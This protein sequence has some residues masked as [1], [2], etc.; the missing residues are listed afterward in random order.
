M[1]PLLSRLFPIAICLLLAL[2]TGCTSP[3]PAAPQATP[4]PDLPG[5]KLA[6]HDEFD[7][8]TG[9]A[10]DAA[11][12][13]YDTGG[14]G[15]GNG[16]LEYYTRETTNAAMDGK[17]AL[18]IQALKLSQ[19]GAGGLK[20]WYGPCQYTSA[21]LLTR[22]KYEFTYGRAEARLKIPAGQGLWPGFW[23]LGS[24]IGTTPWPACGEID[25]LENIGREPS[26]AHGTVHG[27]GYSG[28]GG[29]GGPFTLSSGKLADDFHVYAVE[30]EPKEIRWYLDGKQ[31]FS[32][33]PEK[34]N[35]KWVFDHPFFLILNVAVGGQWPGAPDDA[36]TVF[37]QTMQV[38]YV[39]VYQH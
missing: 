3:V 14:E 2:S 6:W 12:W 13:D 30:W 31:F 20:C 34:V 18:V 17:G 4:I 8:Q 35:G 7:G 5:W 37:P 11:K 26:I 19:P 16:E 32:V 21:R 23:M 1:K 28:A 27:P 33:T 9:A 29:I 22:G 39:R 10:P 36:T 15:W 38:D 24:D 25:I